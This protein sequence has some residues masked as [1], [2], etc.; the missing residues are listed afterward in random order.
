MHFLKKNPQ[1]TLR[2]SVYLTGMLFLWALSFPA[3]GVLFQLALYLIPI[4]T[5]FIKETRS[6]FTT[7]YMKFL[8]LAFCCLVLPTFSREILYTISNFEMLKFDSFE[9]FWRLTLLPICIICLIRHLKISYTNV[10]TTLC[11]ISLSYAVTA[12][13]LQIFAPQSM[14]QW[15]GRMSG[16]MS[17]PN[18]FGSFMALGLILWIE[19]LIHTKHLY[20]AV[21]YTIA[22]AIMFYCWVAAESRSA[23]LAASSSLVLLLALNFTTLSKIPSSKKSIAIISAIIAVAL[24]VIFLVL[25]DHFSKRID[26]IFTAGIRAEVW[27]HYLNQIGPF[28]FW[29][30]PL[31]LYERFQDIS[32]PHNTYLNILLRS[33]V[34]GLLAFLSFLAWMVFRNISTNTR[35]SKLSLSLLTFLAIYCS[36]NSELFGSEMS[37]GIFAIVIIYMLAFNSDVKAE[38][39]T[40]TTST[41]TDEH[42]A[43][44]H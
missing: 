30:Q 28:I 24:G 11:L 41:V 43:Q 3:K 25:G 23:W 17:N 13:A 4:S 8:G 9:I 34:V 1:I 26:E 16:I 33:G 42:N 15:G 14:E 39:L 21:F 2:Q 19:K 44:P 10:S 32:G 12:I 5:L 37:Q 38:A 29:G 35:S 18:P 36:F 6:I 22:S 31:S 27:Q 20:K 7:S 40:D